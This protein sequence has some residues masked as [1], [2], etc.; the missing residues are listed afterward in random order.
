MAWA[1]NQ[2]DSAAYPKLPDADRE[3]LLVTD[4]GKAKWAWRLGRATNV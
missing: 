1:S 4:T 3:I 2:S